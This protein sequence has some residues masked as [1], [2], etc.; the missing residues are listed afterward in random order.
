MATTLKR[1]ADGLITTGPVITLATGEP[2]N[3]Y[4]RSNRFRCSFRGALTKVCN[5]LCDQL[6]DLTM[7]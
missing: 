3:A 5:K 6:D 4:T 1:D 7:F 2:L